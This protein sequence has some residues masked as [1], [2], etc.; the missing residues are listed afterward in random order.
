[1]Q[2]LL[3]SCLGDVCQQ[4]GASG[5]SRYI[6]S[7]VSFR[8]VSDVYGQHQPINR[9]LPDT[10]EVSQVQH[11]LR[12]SGSHS[13]SGN[14]DVVWDLILQSHFEPESTPAG[15]PFLYNVI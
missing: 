7:A 10:P 12:F 4:G 8:T 11:Y 1:M 13:C 14:H 9:M 3:S 5:F 15:D 2:A 6:E